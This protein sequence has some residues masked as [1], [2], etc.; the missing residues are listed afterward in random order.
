[1]EQQWTD[2][3]A[4]RVC[5]SLRRKNDATSL[6]SGVHEQFQIIFTYKTPFDADIII[7]SPMLTA[8]MTYSS[9]LLTLHQ[10]LMRL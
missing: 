8:Y 5:V 10:H 1:M 9:Y 6:T 3:K 2:I 7:K 4:K